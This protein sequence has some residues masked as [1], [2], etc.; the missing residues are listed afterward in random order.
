MGLADPTAR[1]QF[2]R[3]TG[4]SRLRILTAIADAYA[5]PWTER[6]DDAARSAAAQEGWHA[7]YEA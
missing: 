7:Q 3:T 1:E 2:L 6:F 4:A 5:T